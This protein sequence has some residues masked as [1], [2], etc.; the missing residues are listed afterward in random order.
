MPRE[1]YVELRRKRFREREERF[2]REKERIRATKEKD[3]T[4]RLRR[5]I[6][7]V[8]R[9]KEA[10][11]RREK[12]ESTLCEVK[13]TA[14]EIEA[15]AF[16][17]APEM[18]RKT[19]ETIVDADN[20]FEAAD[21]EKTLELS[22]GLAEFLDKTQLETSKKTEKREDRRGEEGKYLYCVVPCIEEESFGHVGMNNDEVYT[23]L[24]KDIAAVVSNSPVEDYEMAEGNIRK[25]EAVLRQVMENHTV[26]P[27]EF[28]T[29][30]KNERILRRLL[31]KAY[32]PT[33]EC[34]RFVDNMV[35]LGLKAVLNNGIVFDDQEKRK[36]CISDILGSLTAIAKQ[37][38]TGELFSDRLVLNA[39][40]L[41]NK[42]DIEA[43]SDEVTRLQEKYPMFKLL[44]SGPWPPY[45]FVYIKIGT[46]GIKIS[47]SG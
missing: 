30:I 39:S 13:K 1:K 11:E 14:K 10:E 16:S 17:C 26:V 8:A 41:V 6:E 36:K 38:V 7:T 37:A 3:R 2:K 32:E 45:S 42:G 23:I 44:Y 12:A 33:R 9:R 27:A 31:T 24:H 29:T 34:L 4:L 15:K 25:H 40:F 43:F 35:E 18:M 19:S 47:K 5:W 21:Y 28:G 20:S 22:N 46:E